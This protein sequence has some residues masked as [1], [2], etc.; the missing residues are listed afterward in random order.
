MHLNKKVIRTIGVFTL[1][2]FILVG[3]NQKPKDAVAKVNGEEISV[4]EFNKYFEE[5]K[6]AYEAQYGEN[7]MSE[8]AEGSKTFEDVIK[9][10]I[11]NFLV[12]K[13]LILDDANAKDITVTDE[14]INEI[15]KVY[16]EQYGGKEK[17]KEILSD[18]DVTME[19]LKEELRQMIIFQKHAENFLK[20]LDLTDEESK[21]FF[22]ENKDNFITVKASHILLETEEEGK[23]ILE[24]LNKGEDFATLATEESV[25]E[26]SAAN[27]GSLNYFKKGMMVKEF[28]DVAFN[29]EPGEVSDLV[30]SEHGYHIIKVEDR[31]ENYEDLK[32]EVVETL[33]GIKYG[34]YLDDL[35][36]KADIEIYLEEKNKSS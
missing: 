20:N 18:N 29:L 5:E 2:V 6:A 36:E 15:L 35:R 33:E 31:I 23:K 34:E 30:K 24:R 3:C 12:E 9:E 7:I 22:E 25:D 17:M 10:N 11:V 8:K 14:E 27:G 1:L 26:G 13:K 4:E 32:E 19:E 21:N 16:E 28:E